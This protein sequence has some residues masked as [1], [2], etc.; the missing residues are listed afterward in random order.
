EPVADVA[1][2]VAEEVA[3]R[4]ELLRFDESLEGRTIALLQDLDELPNQL[5]VRSDPN[6]RLGEHARVW[7][8]LDRLGRPAQLEAEKQALLDANP[9]ADEVAF[10]DELE[11]LE[12][13]L[14]R[15]AILG[16]ERLI[17]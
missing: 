17:R 12:N 15:L 13:G 1:D 8:L 11:P 10:G 9:F 4:L 2:P 16:A 7:R 5:L 6:D 14:E 3:D